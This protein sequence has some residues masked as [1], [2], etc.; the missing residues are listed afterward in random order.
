[1]WRTL[2]SG[3]MLT[4][5]GSFFWAICLLRLSRHA[6][7]FPYAPLV[8]TRSVFIAFFMGIWW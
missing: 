3:D 6:A 4:L 8:I 1:M 2:A 7:S 5:L